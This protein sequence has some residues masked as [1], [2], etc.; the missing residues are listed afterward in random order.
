MKVLGRTTL[1]CALLGVSAC[2][3]DGSADGSAALEDSATS[4]EVETSEQDRTSGD[5]ENLDPVATKITVGSVVSTAFGVTDRLGG[6]GAFAAIVIALDRGYSLPQVLDASEGLDAEAW[7]TVDG[8]RVQPNRSPLGL[9]GPAPSVDEETLGAGQPLGFRRAQPQRSSEQDEYVAFVGE[10]LGEM[11]ARIQL[12]AR[13]DLPGEKVDEIVDGVLERQRIDAEFDALFAE[14]PDELESLA[15][16][17]AFAVAL[18]MLLVGQGYSLED[19]LVAALSGTFDADGVCLFIPG[20]VPATVLRMEGCPPAV[21]ET[22]ATTGDTTEDEPV[23]LC[24]GDFA[25]PYSGVP[26]EG[27][28]TMDVIEILGE[29]DTPYYYTEVGGFLDIAADGTFTLIADTV[30]YG[31]VTIRGE[32]EHAVQVRSFDLSGSIDPATGGGVIVGTTSGTDQQWSGDSPIER[33]SEAL[34]KL[35]VVCDD[36]EPNGFVI[37]GVAGGGGTLEF[38]AR[39]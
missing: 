30:R 6:E 21:N 12:R 23:G 14:D 2:G 15:E 9:V 17:E 4:P 18:T 36:A 13:W 11:W 5:A 35:T 37:F 24:D 16:S 3:G 19:A 31:D 8:T 34:G 27:I 25:P 1:V 22:A 26:I 29:L 39:P 10:T 20:A 7:I 33:S 28:G 38:E 32:P